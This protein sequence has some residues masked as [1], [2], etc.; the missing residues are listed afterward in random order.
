MRKTKSHVSVSGG[1]RESSK[2]RSA[3]SEAGSLL[4]LSSLLFAMTITQAEVE[5]EHWFKCFCFA[6]LE[7]NY[8]RWSHGPEHCANLFH[9]GVLTPNGKREHFDHHLPDRLVTL[10]RQPVQQTVQTQCSGLAAQTRRLLFYPAALVKQLQGQPV[11]ARNI[12]G[13]K[14]VA[15]L[16]TGAMQI[17]RDAS[18]DR[19]RR[20]GLFSQQPGGGDFSLARVRFER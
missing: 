12:R 15:C 17:R 8:A 13:K 10:L 19:T 2:E 1:N 16:D 5:A 20:A 4:S 14:S 11:I 6:L 3:E 7:L 18:P 9:A